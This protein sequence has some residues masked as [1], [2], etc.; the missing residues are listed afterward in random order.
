MRAAP[1]A[2]HSV[3][4]W[5]SALHRAG[6]QLRPAR[7]SPVVAQRNAQSL[8]DRTDRTKFALEAEE[9]LWG[10]SWNLGGVLSAEEGCLHGGGYTAAAL[11]LL[12]DLILSKLLL[13]CVLLKVCVCSSTFSVLCALMAL[14]VLFMSLVLTQIV[15]SICNIHVFA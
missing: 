11:L 4:R 9:G 6:A 3:R 13:F 14:Y 10:A 7:V 1:G 15:C 12:F 8:C 5:T 2:Q